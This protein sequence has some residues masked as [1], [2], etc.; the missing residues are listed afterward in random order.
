MEGNNSIII[1]TRDGI[2]YAPNCSTVLSINIDKY[3]D[4][5]YDPK[6]KYEISN[7]TEIGYLTK[8]NIIPKENEFNCAYKRHWV[9]KVGMQIA[10]INKNKVILMNPANIYSVNSIQS[11]VD[12]LSFK[13]DPSIQETILINTDRGLYKTIADKSNLNN[14]FNSDFDTGLTKNFRNIMKRKNFF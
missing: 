10:I 8:S 13:H 3:D 1:Y 5:T 7:K 14:I 4:C 11:E 12:I 2:I 6:V 9:R